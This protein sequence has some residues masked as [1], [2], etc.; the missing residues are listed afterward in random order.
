MNYDFFFPF[1]T[2]T[3]T[4]LATHSTCQLCMV[5]SLYT[6]HFLSVRAMCMHATFYPVLKNCRTNERTKLLKSCGSHFFFCSRL[7]SRYVFFVYFFRFCFVAKCVRCSKLG[8]HVRLTAK[9]I[10]IHRD[11]SKPTHSHQFRTSSNIFNHY[12]CSGE[13]HKKKE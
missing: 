6:G 13:R 9:H 5:T 8:P 2:N 7:I 1:Q 11:H 12:K 3:T 10:P 4:Y